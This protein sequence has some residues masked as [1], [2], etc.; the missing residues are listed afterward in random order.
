M[1]KPT[2]VKKLTK[3]QNEAVIA[4][5]LDLLKADIAL[6]VESVQT[7]KQRVQHAL[8]GCA[9]HWHMTGS[10]LGL[11]EI[12]NLFITDINSGVN[13]RAVVAWCEQ[14]LGMQVHATEDK[15]VFGKK[16][17]KD[18]DLKAIAAGKQWYELKPITPFSFDLYAAV[19]ALQ[20]KAVKAQAEFNKDGDVDVKLDELVMASLKQLADL[21]KAQTPKT[22]N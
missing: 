4:K 8:M 18:L 7:M 9:S 13:T 12:I 10:N 5:S 3:A 21:A 15:L 1:T 14:N 17:A 16:Q 22:P 6:A 20:K 11:G 2:S 19:E